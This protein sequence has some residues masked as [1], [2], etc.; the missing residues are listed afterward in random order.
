MSPDEGRLEDMLREAQLARTFIGGL[1]MDEFEQDLKTQ[2]AVLRCLDIIGEAAN[3]ISSETRDKLPALPWTQII[4]QRHVAIHHYHK[5]EMSRIWAT[6][7]QDLP[8]L[9]ATLEAY[10]K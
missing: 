6:V 1:S 7:K 8:P 9:I 3:N 5:V 4:R 10:L 2:H